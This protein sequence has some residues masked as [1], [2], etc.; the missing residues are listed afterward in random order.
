MDSSSLAV[1]RSTMKRAL[2]HH[3]INKWPL[4]KTKKVVRSGNEGIEGTY[5]ETPRVLTNL[6]GPPQQVVLT[7]QVILDKN[8]MWET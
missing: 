2:R 4:P 8:K 1:S 6:L 5:N 3:K 7:K